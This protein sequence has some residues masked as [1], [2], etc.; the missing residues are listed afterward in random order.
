MQALSKMTLMPARRLESF[1]PAMKNKGRIQVGADADITIF[2]ASKI[3]DRAT[4]TKPAQHSDGIEYV[5]VN[6]TLVLDKGESVNGVY[7]GKGVKAE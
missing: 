7:P 1:A 5:M 3:I 6:G 4:Y 2:D